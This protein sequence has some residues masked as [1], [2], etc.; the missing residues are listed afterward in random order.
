MSTS[1]QLDVVTPDKKVVSEKV[2]YVCCPGIE[3]E[4]GV[5]K[6]HVALLSALKIGALRFDIDGKQQFVF[7]SGG[8]ADVNANVVT[9]L[10]EAAELSDDIDKS[11]AEEA[12][13]R[14]EERLAQRIDELDV[15]RAEAALH[16]AVTRLS[17]A[18]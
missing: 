8:F 3:G 18:R 2:D 10:A 14:A 12:R 5:L 15:V 4:F 11:R 16:R 13:K 1:L 6:D 7:I 17:L 9:V